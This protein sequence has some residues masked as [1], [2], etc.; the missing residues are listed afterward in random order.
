MAGRVQVGMKIEG[1]RGDRALDTA[2]R[3]FLNDVS[4]FFRWSLAARPC[5]FG[6]PILGSGSLLRSHGMAVDQ[7]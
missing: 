5:S 3:R 7:R 1:R 6:L 2:S 4:A